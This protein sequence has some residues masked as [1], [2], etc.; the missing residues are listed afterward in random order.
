MATSK[1]GK[2]VSEEATAEGL[3]LAKEAGNAYRKMVE[4]FIENVADSGTKKKSGDYLIGFAVEEAEPLCRLLG[5]K[6]EVKEPPK[7]ANAHLEVVVMDKDDGRFIP[8]LEVNVTVI[9]P[10]G[11]E[12]GTFHLPFLWHPTMYHYGRSITIPKKGKYSVRIHIEPPTFPRH[13]KVNG[14]RYGKPVT[15]EIKD[16]EMEKGRR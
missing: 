14:R 16:I 10:E 3:R 11:E 5:G 8:Q 2:K 15:V 6:V 12:I 1:K 9:D 7:A 13:D 4:Y